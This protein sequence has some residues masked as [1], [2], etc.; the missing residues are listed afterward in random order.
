MITIAD[1]IETL[2][3]VH[4]GVDYPN[5]YYMDDWFPKASK[6]MLFV[7]KINAFFV[8]NQNN[9]FLSVLDYRLYQVY[10]IA[11]L[12]VEISDISRGSLVKL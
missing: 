6:E 7:L 2:Q 10:S 12:R 5:V 8:K 1:R 4:A 3:R 9:F 11:Y